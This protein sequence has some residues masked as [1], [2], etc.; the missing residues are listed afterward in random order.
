MKCQSNRLC[1]GTLFTGL[2][3]IRLD[4]LVVGVDPLPG[5]FTIGG[6]W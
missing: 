6:D 2:P 1:L 4:V 5:D 3:E